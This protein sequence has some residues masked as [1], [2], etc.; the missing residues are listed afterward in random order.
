MDN[1]TRADGVRLAYSRQEGKGPAVVFLSGYMSDMT[2]G[3]ALALDAW[4][5]GKGR[6]YLRF[7]YGGCGASEGRFE[8]QTLAGWLADAL[9]LIDTLIEGP[10]VLVGS[11]MGGW[12]MLLT[13]LAPLGIPV[14]GVLPR[15]DVLHL[16]E[17]HLGLVMPDEVAG[18]DA[19]VTAAADAL[20]Q[21]AVKFVFERPYLLADGRLS[22]EIAFG[23][24]R[25]AL[26]VDKIAKYFQRFDMHNRDDGQILV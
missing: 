1:L 21:T 14:L 20:E 11:S 7:D 18:F 25:K 9:L 2:G 15:R 22:D 13:A 24:E 10:V 23:R 4:A 3:K 5:A 17:R 8:D 12:L 19:V 16:P 6:A 26:E